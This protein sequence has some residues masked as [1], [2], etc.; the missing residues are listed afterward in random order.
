M[1]VSISAQLFDVSPP[2]VLLDVTSSPTVV[3]PLTV[4]RVHDDG[5]RHRVVTGRSVLVGSWSG[6]DRHCP[7]N[8][9]VQYAATAEGQPESAPTPEDVLV[10]MG[11][12]WLIHPTRPELSFPIR[13][14][15]G[16]QQPMTYA[17]S[18][19]AFDVLQQD[20][21]TDALPVARN[22]FT[23]SG[24]QGKVK[25]QI[26]REAEPAVRAFFRDGGPVL[27]NG[28][29]GSSDYPWM[30]LIAKNVVVS[31]PGGIID[32]P[33]REVEFDIR[34]CRGP[35]A[36]TAALNTYPNVRSK[37]SYAAVKAL[38]GTYRAMKLGIE[39]P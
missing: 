15:M 38:Y 35:D 32:H 17:S 26:A 23:R 27:L 19:A 6:V 10:A 36:D 2:G 21:G 16:P 33:T 20:E 14:I 24:A 30:W 29:W 39:T 3:A 12:P 31:N 25:I 22:D 1:T 7:F 8:R 11:G 4:W 9:V 5:S 28:A 34:E 37:G 13:K 18:A